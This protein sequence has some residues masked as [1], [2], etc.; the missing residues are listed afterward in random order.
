VFWLINA[1]FDFVSHCSFVMFFL[2]CVSIKVV[3]CRFLNEY[4]YLWTPKANFFVQVSFQREWYNTNCTYFVHVF[5]RDLCISLLA[6]MLAL[7]FFCCHYHSTH[8]VNKCC[9][10]QFSL[11]KVPV[12]Y[13]QYKRCW[14]DLPLHTA[15]WNVA[16][17]RYH[18]VLFVEVLLVWHTMCTVCRSI[19]GM[20][21]HV[22]CL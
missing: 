17:M 4:E 3:I 5:I 10:K 21:Y 13:C 9:N 6:K 15:S 16:G 20:T 8:N 12:L 7:I 14:C 1:F 18:C 19:A 22:Y 11:V 2:P